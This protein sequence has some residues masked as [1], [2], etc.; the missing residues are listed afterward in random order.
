VNP[1]DL[2]A[3]LH[4]NPDDREEHLYALVDRVRDTGDE[5]ATAA[6][7]AVVSHYRDF[8]RDL[9]CRALNEAALFG[10]ATL[11]APLLAA[12]VD[13]DYDCQAWAARGCTALG[14]RAAVALLVPLLADP[15][16]YNW[17]Y[18]EKIEKNACFLVKSLLKELAIMARLSRDIDIFL[19]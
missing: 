7:R 5:S 4:G 19:H 13:V 8:D 16:S 2:H 3:L 14:F 17:L 6:L 12:L 11:E 9:Y 18:K 10:D 1:A 15:L